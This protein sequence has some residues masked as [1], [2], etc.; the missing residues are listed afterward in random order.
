M[1]LSPVWLGFVLLAG[2]C[3]GGE[4]ASPVTP[5]QPDVIRDSVVAPD[6]AA[7][8]HSRIALSAWGHTVQV[9]DSRDQVAEVFP[10]VQRAIESSDLPAQFGANFKARVWERGNDGFGVI[11]YG[12]RDGKGNVCVAIA[13]YDQCDE[14]K[15]AEIIAAQETAC[16]RKLEPSE[17]TTHSQ[18]WFAEDADVRLMVCAYGDSKD[19]KKVT[20][21]IGTISAM[22][23]LGASPTAAKRDSGQVEEILKAG[24]S[25][26]KP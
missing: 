13:S 4:K 12:T 24:G 21:A 17:A 19:S 6:F 3:Q 5:P 14:Q 16:D 22:D 11:L 7:T 1:R 2:G 20:V 8:G 26:V 15:L 10:A 25:T 23:A 9:G 18:Y